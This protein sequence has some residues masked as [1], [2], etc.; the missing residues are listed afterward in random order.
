[1]VALAL[2]ASALAVRWSVGLSSDEPSAVIPGGPSLRVSARRSG[3]TFRVADGD[4]LAPGDE[5]HFAVTPMGL[6]YLLIASVA[7]DGQPRVY[8]P[9]HGTASGKIDP[10]RP[11][12]L[13]DAIVLDEAPGPERV[14]A[15]LSQQPLGAWMVLEALRQLAAD[16]DRALRATHTLPIAVPAQLSLRLEKSP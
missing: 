4:K 14:F 9:P 13:P 10:R 15:L 1:V 11:S 12:E 2:G 8:F 3:R 5:L 6:G 16:G 7:G